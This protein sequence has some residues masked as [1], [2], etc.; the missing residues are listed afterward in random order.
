MKSADRF[1]ILNHCQF[2]KNNYQ[3]RF[4]Y[5]DA[6]HTMSVF[7]GLD[8]IISKKYVDPFNDWS[9][10]K[11]KLSDKSQILE[12]FDSC[13]SDNLSE[14][15]CKII[16]TLASELKISTEILYD[17]ETDLKSSDR[18]IWICKN[19]GAN[20]YLAGSGGKNYMDIEKFKSNN[21]DVIFQNL[22]DSDKIHT[23]DVLSANR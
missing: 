10:I 23:L 1:V 16:E 5:R 19:L 14:T 2:E 9:R 8:P 6:W 15:N 4:F 21:I 17:S 3:N 7:K 20:A 18:L 11:R 13:I 12:K 22:D